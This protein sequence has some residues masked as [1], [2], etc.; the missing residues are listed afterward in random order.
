MTHT[1]IVT[2]LCEMSAELEEI[3]EKTE[4]PSDSFYLDR[5][6][7]QFQGTLNEMQEGGRR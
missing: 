4:N 5:L 2:R 1:E 7:K 3:K 6:S